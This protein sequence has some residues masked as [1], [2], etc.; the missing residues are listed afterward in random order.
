[1]SNAYCE[2]DAVVVVHAFEIP[3]LPYSSGPCKSLN[4]I[5]LCEFSDSDYINVSI[6]CRGVNYKL[7]S[8]FTL[9][10]FAYYEEWSQMV[11]DLREQA[12]EMMKVYEKKCK[13]KKVFEKC[14]CVK[15]N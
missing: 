6:I 13:E 1:M 15:Q 11:N 14:Y 8:F 5:L 4:F 12:K 7:L 9:V 10:V 3:P 2:G